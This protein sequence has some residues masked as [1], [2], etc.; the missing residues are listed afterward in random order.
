MQFCNYKDAYSNSDNTNIL[1]QE[2]TNN[3]ILK[4]NFQS[5]VDEE[6][7]ENVLIQKQDN[8]C[9]CCKNNHDNYIIILLILLIVIILLK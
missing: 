1:L 2:Y 7:P 6:L 8:C 4:E 9:K 3:T 5:M